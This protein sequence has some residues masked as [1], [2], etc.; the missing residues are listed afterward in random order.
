MHLKLLLMLFKGS[1]EDFIYILAGLV[2]VA[3][4]IYKGSQKQKKAKSGGA[5]NK[6]SKSVIEDFIG[7]YLGV[8]EEI[9]YQDEAVSS[10]KGEEL[11]EETGEVKPQKGT[12]NPEVISF[13]DEYEKD[14]SFKEKVLLTQEEDRIEKIRVTDKRKPIQKK[15]LRFNVKK[16]VIY[17]EILRRPTY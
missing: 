5:E 16:A 7:D 15:K 11:I 4:S 8:K 13:D 3:F 9:V 12:Y 14:N 6:K 1:F 17:S 2:W 10:E